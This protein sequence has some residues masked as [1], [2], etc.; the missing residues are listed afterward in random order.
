MTTTISPS[1]GHGAVLTQ[2]GVG[3]TPG[4]DAID[5]RR[6]AAG[7]EIEG[8]LSLGS[9]AVTQ[10]GAGA[11][12]TVDI[13]A[14]T[15]KGA[16]VEGDAVTAQGIYY[17]APHSAVINEAISAAHATLP[18]NDLVVLE[19]KDNQHDAGGANIA[20]VRVITGTATSGAT[21]FTDIGVTGTPALPASAIPLAVVNVPA[22]AASI[23]NANIDDRR[24]LL[25]RFGSSGKAIIATEESTTSGAFTTLATPDR[26]SGIVMPTDG[27]IFVL[28]RANVK[29]TGMT[30]TPAVTITI[31]G[32]TIAYISGTALTADVTFTAYGFAYTNGLR[33]ISDG[34]A[35]ADV[36]TGQA[37][38]IPIPVFAAA[39]TYTIEAKYA[40]GGGTITARNRKLWVW[41]Q[42]YG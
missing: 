27:L 8:V 18:R 20:Q 3:T 14:S 11:N 37:V 12:M 24:P 9:Y 36:T 7:T 29:Q 22:A 26:V 34:A 32:N 21:K 5:L 6:H 31:N 25:A 42:G 19:I 39:G 16:R 1:L 41:A 28:F 4:Y 30:G 38:G 13:A 15:G 23:T 35:V 17:V 10:R 40:A 2:Q 33:L